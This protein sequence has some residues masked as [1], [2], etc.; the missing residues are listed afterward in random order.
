MP[1]R[2]DRSILEGQ[3]IV[4]FRA[5][6]RSKQ[7]L[8]PY[9]RKLITFLTWANMTADEFVNFAK[10]KPKDAEMKIIEYIL[11]E[12]KRI[13]A[14]VIVAGT[15]SNTV[16][17]VR[18]LL[19]MNDVLL[20]WKKIR[21]ILPSV[22]RYADD[23]IPTLKELREIVTG[24]DFRGKALILT[25][26]SSGIREGAIPVLKVGDVK[27]IEHEGKIIAARL[28]VY[29]GEPEQYTAFITPEAYGAIQTYLDYR[30]EHGENLSNS[31]PLIR[32][33]FEATTMVY[34]RAIKPDI[35]KPI[36]LGEHAIRDYFN[37]LL[38]ELGFRKQKARRHEFSVHSLRKYFKTRA[39]SGGMK[40]I[41]V[42]T[43]MNHSTGISDSY[44]KATENELLQSYLKIAHEL[45][46][47]EV[48]E[49]KREMEIQ[50][51]SHQLDLKKVMEHIANLERRL[52]SSAVA[53]QQAE[54][55]VQSG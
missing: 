26:V 37:R 43:L 16:K 27:P 22:K 47:S 29:A 5:A 6:I 51:R 28:T 40:P 4:L 10:R 11:E 39:E 36:P 33:K 53:V 42:E 17:C 50:E 21:R 38:F 1:K 13:D 45:Q 2:I 30:S 54:T 14:K 23:R 48:A 41:E 15:L 52:G 9:E 8:D 35:N 34:Y 31:S 19:E 3:S 25:L 55:R 46:V 18:L 7:T 32:D 24:A 20:N 12:K 49:M 44:W